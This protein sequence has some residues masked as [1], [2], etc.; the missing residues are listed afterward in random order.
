MDKFYRTKSGC[1]GLVNNPYWGK[2]YRAIPDPAGVEV[3]DC[4]DDFMLA[5]NFAKLPSKTLYSIVDFFRHFEE[6]RIEA[7]VILLRGEEDVSLW[8]VVVPAQIVTGGS[9]SSNSK[10]LCDLLTG[11]MFTEYPDGWVYAG[12]M[13]LHP[14]NL[15]AFWSSTD[16]ENEI[17]N[18]GMHCT[19]GYVSQHKFNI[20]C[21]ICLGGNRYVF[22]PDA[23]IDNVLLLGE[24]KQNTTLMYCDYGV[25]QPHPKSF[26]QVK[27]FG[28]KSY[29]KTGTQN[30]PYRTTKEI[31]PHFDALGMYDWDNDVLLTGLDPQEKILD[32]IEKYM[33][34]AT[35]DEI[36]E[37]FVKISR[38]YF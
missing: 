1:Y 22:Q 16:D 3:P 26:E 5:E 23:V 29:V 37:L 36:D 11:E 32:D 9:V 27:E 28:I 12:T 13:H 17:N 14:G 24:N 7:Q 38:F 21:S 6:K 15:D 33:F 19:V 30:Y 35:P 8:R 18:P 31:N 20:C 2:Y 25:V 10:S 34:G 4:I